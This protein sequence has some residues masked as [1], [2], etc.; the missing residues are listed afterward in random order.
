MGS[1]SASGKQLQVSCKS[2]IQRLLRE[3]RNFRDCLERISELE[4]LGGDGRREF[5]LASLKKIAAHTA[6]HVPHC[7]DTFRAAGFDPAKDGK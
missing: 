2:Y 3:G 7:R 5:Q 4:R 6:K 1:L